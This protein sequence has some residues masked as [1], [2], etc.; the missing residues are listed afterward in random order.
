MNHFRGTPSLGQRA[1]WLAAIAVTA[2]AILSS[3]APLQRL[4]LLAYDAIEPRYRPA[5]RFPPSTLIA[6]DEVSLAVLGHWPWNRAI[7]GQLINRLSDAGVAAVGLPLLLSEPAPGD[8]ELVAAMTRAGNVVL[9]VAPYFPNPPLP[10]VI[11]IQPLS[12]LRAAAAALGHVDVHLDLDGLARRTFRNAGSGTAQ[13]RALALATL[14][15]LQ[16]QAALAAQGSDDSAAPPAAD[17]LD[18]VPGHWIRRGELLLPY[19]DAR[20]APRLLSYADVLTERALAEPLGGQAVFVG[21]TASGLSGSLATPASVHHGPMSAVEFHVRTYDALRNGQVYHTAARG[22]TLALSLLFLAVPALLFPLIGVR[23]ALACGALLLL[24]ALV[25]GMALYGLRL[26]IPPAAAT[27]GFVLG[28]LSWFAVYLYRTRGS[29]QRARR[30]ADATLK[31]IADAVITI[32]KHSRVVLMNPIAEQLT[33]HEFRAMAGRALEEVLDEFTSD[34]AQITEMLAACLK[35]RHTIRLPE[36]IQWSVPGEAPSFL[37]LTAT[38]VD[39]RGE[40]AVLAFSDVTETMQ[41]TAKLKHEATHDPLTGLPNRT[42]LLDRLGQALALAKRRNSLLALLFVDLDRFKRINDSLGHGAGD[43]VLNIVAERLAAAVRT[44]DTIARWGGDEFIVLMDNLL[45][46]NAVI[47]VAQKILTLLEHE[48]DTADGLRIVLSCSIGIG[49][50]PTDSD[51]AGTLLS[52]ADQA[53]YRGKLEGGGNFTFY[54]PEMNIWSRDRLD[55]E[56]ALREAL[57]KDEFEL[58]Y[59][60][61]IKL[62]TG[63]LVGLEALIRWRKP[64]GG[65]RRPDE[66][67]PASEDS[68]LIRNL[69]E[70]VIR[71]AA[72]QMACWHFE[73][74][75][76][77]PVGVNVSAR[78]C[79]DMSVVDIIRTALHSNGLEPHMLKVELTESTAMRDPDRVAML[80]RSI[81]ELGAG[82]AV[83]DFGT[84]YSS[85]SLLKRFPIDELKIDKSFVGDIADYGDDAAIVRGTIA[86]AH[87]LGMKVVAEGVETAA[88]LSFLAAHGC[89]TGQGYLFSQPLPADEIRHWLVAVPPHVL[90]AVRMS[91]T[92]S[93]RER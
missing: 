26:W 72:A 90:R 79:S 11:E 27:S 92:E 52:M 57:L 59:Q 65:Y 40:G 86:L 48:V 63:E 16:P 56:G 7:H 1:A 71:Q 24:P 29:L 54:S 14:D 66:F 8:D 5:A 42:L 15:H 36:P 67:I 45:D 89:N 3:W 33:G 21:A 74:L 58:F 35:L 41:V 91:R 77:V 84:G 10:E 87:G 18:V 30:D 70:W 44:G 46:R 19:P 17:R 75:P 12:E 9:P 73:G 83:D 55:M 69:G 49:I 43:H 34:T 31:S 32:D 20:G 82:I 47:V 62:E 85:L 25:S 4:D 53:M 80:L 50:G 78:Q 61:Q 64:G 23:T 13:W 93:V 51:H 60:P 81:D 38:P 22:L 37:R 6:I 39:G 68:G 88:Q 28:Y 76:L 2:L